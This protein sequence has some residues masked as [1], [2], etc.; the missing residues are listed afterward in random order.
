MHAEGLLFVHN[1]WVVTLTPPDTTIMSTQ[2]TKMSEA[3]LAALGPDLFLLHHS[4]RM[5]L[6]FGSA[7]TRPK[8]VYELRFFAA[9]D[10]HLAALPARERS[11]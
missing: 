11:S 10:E 5:L 1:G 8:E 6:A 2:F 4:T 7:L 3:L 9:E